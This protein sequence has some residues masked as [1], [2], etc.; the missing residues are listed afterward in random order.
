MTLW[1]VKKTPYSLSRTFHRWHIPIRAA[2]PFQSI[3]MDLAEI[4]TQW[5]TPTNHNVA[6]WLVVIDVHSR[7]VWLATLTSK[8]ATKVAEALQDIIDSMPQKPKQIVSDQGSEFKAAT[9]KYLDDK[10]IELV[11]VRSGDKYK[12]ALVE[13]VIRT[14]KEGVI[15]HMYHNNTHKYTDALPKIV[16]RYNG[17]R[18][19]TTGHKP[20][21]ALHKAYA[22]PPL[23]PQKP[24]LKLGTFVR[25]RNEFP[26]KQTFSKITTP[27]WSNEIYQVIETQGF[28]GYIVRNVH[29]LHK[30]KHVYRR[31]QLMP[32]NTTT[33]AKPIPVSKEGKIAVLKKQLQRKHR[34]ELTTQE[35]KEALESTS[36]P[37]RTRKPVK[38]L[39]HEEPQHSPKRTKTKKTKPTF[40][41]KKSTPSKPKPK[42]KSNRKRKRSAPP[43]TRRSKRIRKAPDRYQMVTY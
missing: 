4:P 19:G 17:H 25:I 32:V 31:W 34:L 7:Y 40:K 36:R 22:L 39:G 35:L 21:K 15:A 30:S 33:A 27:R 42:S 1:S 9:K 18:H 10:K 41:K 28:G 8:K 5:K 11:M 38:R 3:Q 24:R 26:S 43:P 12:T 20:N 2:K 6:Y 29:T 23:P 14:I 37:K 13:R 16:A